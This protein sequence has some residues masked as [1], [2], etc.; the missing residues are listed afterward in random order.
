M[1]ER[2]RERAGLGPNSPQTH[3]AHVER[4]AQEINEVPHVTQIT[5]HAHGKYLLHLL[6]HKPDD[7]E[8]YEQL[9]LAG[10]LAALTQRLL[11]QVSLHVG[12]AK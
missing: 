1:R 5:S 11:R 3:D 7:I 10:Y 9:Q 4:V 6:P 12:R 2:E 8:H